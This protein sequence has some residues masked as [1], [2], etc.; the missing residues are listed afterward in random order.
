MNYE[1]VD[2]STG[3]S[4]ERFEVA[5]ASELENALDS[6]TEAFSGWRSRPLGERT[7]HVERLADLLESRA[8]EL[9]GLMAREMGKPLAEGRA[10]AA[11]CAWV[12]RYYAEN[13]ASFLDPVPLHSDGSE[14]WVRYDPLGPILA[15]MPWNFPFWQFFRFAAPALAAGNVALLKHSPNTPRC[16][17]RIETLALEAGLPTGVVRNLFLTDEQAAH[18][19]ADPR[20]RGVTFTGSTR[21]GK[22]VAAVAGAHMK[23]IVLELG[24]NDPFVVFEDADLD[25]ALDTAVTSRCLNS[26][27][28]CI[29]AKRFLVQAP[30][31][32]AFRDGLV[33]RMSSL[34]M[35]NPAE[36]RV[37]LGPLARRD[38]RDRLAD[39]VARTVAL[40]ARALC[41][42]EVPV[43]DGFFYPATVL[44]DAPADSPAATEELFGP[45]A[46]LFPFDTEDDA[47]AMANGTGYGLGAGV[48]TADR[49]RA[50]RLVRELESGAV[51]VNGLVKSDPRLPFGG[52]KDSGHGRELGRDGML[53]FVN[54]KTVWVGA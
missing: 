3:E 48:W 35:G 27:Q 37:Q 45:V 40:G 29:A 49:E 28:S 5:T 53:E 33:E 11:K 4:V 54:R 18:T 42:G 31:F 7:G 16:A 26:G 9:A 14:A 19:I 1:S 47:V 34:T 51:F 15:I 38:L 20:V 25:S 22:Q 24:G 23:P 13:A 2:P 43:R 41:G 30:V 52:V 50:E 32:E 46:S 17:R 10:E 21:S 12:C 44:V 39:Q 6:A 8:V 36:N